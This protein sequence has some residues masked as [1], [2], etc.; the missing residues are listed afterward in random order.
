MEQN[1]ALCACAEM[2]VKICHWAFTV[3][4]NVIDLNSS[5]ELW[6]LITSNPFPTIR[7]YTTCSV[8]QGTGISLGVANITLRTSDL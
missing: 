6:G 3:E 7:I 2:L 8:F 1:C 5:F 4:L